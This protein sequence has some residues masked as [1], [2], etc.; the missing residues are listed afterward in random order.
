M[1]FLETK[2]LS[3]RFGGL[4]AVDTVD[5]RLEAGEIRAVIGPNGAGK[6][7]LVSMICGRLAPSDG[8]ILFDGTEITHLPPWERVARGIVYTFQITSVF[9]N[10]SCFENVALAAQ[11]ALTLGKAPW[12]TVDSSAL[13]SSVTDALARVHLHERSDTPAANLPYGHQRLL[14]VA[15]SLALKPKLLVLDEPTQGLSEAEITDFCS[16]VREIAADATILLIEH[17]MDVVMELAER[18]TVMSNGAILAEG[19]PAE[20]TANAA[21]QQAYLGA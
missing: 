3:R 5:F 2:A 8:T 6:T 20:I 14:E 12:H 15:M 16:L 7:T 10:L 13:A 1:S 18:I 17:N 4:T 11:R 21:V 9:R 19:T